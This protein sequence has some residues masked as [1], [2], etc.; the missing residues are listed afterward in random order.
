MMNAYSVSVAA[1]VA[2][3]FGMLA[4]AYVGHRAGR[5]RLQEDP[6]AKELSTGTIDAA[7]LSLLG[8]LIA[9]TFTGAYARFDTRRQL[10]VDETNAISTAYLRLDLLPSESQAGLREKFRE[11]VTSRYELWLKLSDREAA[12]EEY[13]RSANLQ[14]EIWSQ[15]IAASAGSEW[16]SARL[17]LL[18]ALNEMIDITTTRLAAMQTH[19][20]LIIFLLLGALSLVSA[21]LSG[22]AMAKSSRIATAHVV[23]FAAVASIAV[24][25]ILDIEYPRFGLVR[26][27]APQRLLSDLREQID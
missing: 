25:V 6:D 13:G 19:P 11:Y 14:N 21:W 7:V 17:L 16:Q 22:Y 1:S 2:L 10:V 24:Y 3:F 18:P 8:L 20:P 27:D 12:L 9:F 23:G 15:A 26:L 5:R 4:F